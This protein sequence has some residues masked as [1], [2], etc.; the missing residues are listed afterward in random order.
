MRFFLITILLVMSAVTARP[1][2][3]NHLGV[4][5][6]LPQLSVHAIYQGLSWAGYG[7]GTEE[8]GMYLQRGGNRQ[9]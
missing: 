1:V 5:D 8:G 2:Y 9:L 3:F 7:F 4:K 6:G